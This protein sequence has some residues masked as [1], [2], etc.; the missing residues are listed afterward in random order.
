MNKKYKFFG[1]L[2][3]LLF[4]SLNQT[5][6]V[7]EL[8]NH[9]LRRIR[10]FSH[11]QWFQRDHSKVEETVKGKITPSR[12][13]PIEDGYKIVVM[14][15]DK[16]NN[17]LWAN[18]RE[19][20]II[21]LDPSSGRQLHRENMNAYREEF[22]PKIEDFKKEFKEENPDKEVIAILP[23]GNLF[24]NDW[25]TA[26]IN[27]KIYHRYGEPVEERV[28]TMLVVKKTGQVSIE[29]IKLERGE[30]DKIYEIKDDGTRENITDEVIYATYGQ[31]IVENGNVVDIVREGQFDQFE[32]LR[33]LLKF[34]RLKWNDEKK[35]IDIERILGLK[36][37]NKLGGSIYFGLST[38]L[39]N[40]EMLRNALNGEEI[41]IPIKDE[42]YK[43]LAERRAWDSETG[44][45]VSKKEIEDRIDKYF[46]ELVGYLRERSN[47]AEIE[48]GKLK[49]ILAI[50][51][52][53]HSV[54]GI[55][56][57]EKIIIPKIFPGKQGRKGATI[58]NAAEYM[59]N[60]GAYNVLLIAN[61]GDAFFNDYEEGEQLSSS[62]ER[63]GF[64][65]VIFIVRA[66]N[67]D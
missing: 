44:E 21:F 43:V 7:S 33:H 19:A 31:Q 48:H 24:W 62:E 34:P 20:E 4:V 56:K 66:K 27:G 55:D 37:K 46:D 50:N 14:V 52:Y 39:D 64:T 38:L 45:F 22:L 49:I 13:F 67:Q 54:I 17:R 57:S 15:A 30:T 58:K 5:S 40:K 6:A 35:P 11:S 47:S 23:N 1:I 3:I 18:R 61:G 60:H 36:F 51:K 29:K 2:L 32:D 41:E 8:S 25:F 12:N 26:Y 65:S 53:P 63:V 16:F 59:I 9:G 28:Y 42:L 10:E